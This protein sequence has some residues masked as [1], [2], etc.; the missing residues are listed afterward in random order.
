MYTKEAADE[1]MRTVTMSQQV[2]RNISAQL[3]FWKR[4]A[5]EIVQSWD[6]AFRMADMEKRLILIYLANDIVQLS[7]PSGRQ[8]LEAFNKLLP[9]AF[10]HM[11]KHSDAGM[12]QK[13][14]KLVKVWRSR[15]IWGHKVQGIYEELVKGVDSAPEVQHEDALSV[16]RLKLAEIFALSQRGQ[17]LM[18]ADFQA[19][20]SL[21][22]AAAQ[23][24]RHIDI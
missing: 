1:L 12:Q 4:H 14:R 23:V 19:R 24:R 2:I 22:E 10:K 16:L 11:V 5:V 13:L 17:V 15:S 6:Q 9:E 3:V 20:K 8:F 21:D 7:K 18:A